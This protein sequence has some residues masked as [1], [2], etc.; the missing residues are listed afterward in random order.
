MG[1]LL[2]RDVSAKLFDVMITLSNQP[3]SRV[4]AYCLTRLTVRSMRTGFPSL[5]VLW[6]QSPPMRF[7]MR[8]EHSD[9]P[10]RFSRLPSPMLSKPLTATSSGRLLERVAHGKRSML[11]IARHCR[12][13]S[14]RASAAS[15]FPWQ[16]LNINQR[17]IAI[18]HTI[19]QLRATKNCDKYYGWLNE[20]IDSYFS[21]RTRYMSLRYLRTGHCALLWIPE[22]ITS[23]A[24]R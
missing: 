18:P 7:A 17:R 9:K 3:E 5:S 12:V 11:L 13:L 23:T 14:N 10:G 22:R 19:S 2:H 8:I 4:R 15:C 6:M 21:A 20:Y 1:N 16:P 24:L